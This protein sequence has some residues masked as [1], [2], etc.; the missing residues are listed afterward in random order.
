MVEGLGYPLGP[1]GGLCGLMIHCGI[2]D[3][4][5]E[6]FDGLDADLHTLSLQLQREH[7]R[8]RANSKNT[9]VRISA[10]VSREYEKKLDLL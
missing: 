9:A 1:A 5:M 4:E 3:M 8:T 7:G 10:V 6:W 2:P